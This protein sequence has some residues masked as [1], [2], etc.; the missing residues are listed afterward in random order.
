[1]GKLLIVSRN[2]DTKLILLAIF[3]SSMTGNISWH[4][5]FLTLFVQK[6]WYIELDSPTSMW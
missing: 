4:A 6:T 1:M 5:F 3:D 2:Q